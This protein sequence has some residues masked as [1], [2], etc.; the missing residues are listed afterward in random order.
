MLSTTWMMFAP[1]CRSMLRMIAGV[2]L[3]QA[4][5]SVFSTESFTA[6]TS[7]SFTG[8]PLR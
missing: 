3:A 6:A 8:A 1:G 5:C 7:E 2:V 4:A